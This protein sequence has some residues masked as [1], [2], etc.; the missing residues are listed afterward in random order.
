MN[1]VILIGRITK[2]PE[3]KFTQQ[4]NTSY[5]SFTLAV[6]RPTSDPNEKKADFINCVAWRETATFIG[7][8]IKKGYLLA[9]EGA[10]QTR[11]YIDNS[12]KTVY[13]TEVLVNRCDNLQPRE[14]QPQQPNN[15]QPNQYGV[16][17][18]AM[19][20][21]YYNQPSVYQQPQQSVYQQHQQQQPQLTFNDDDLPF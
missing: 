20:N 18:N 10:I 16:N 11:N 9:V 14:Q 6:N 15:Y 12:N 2:D 17:P 3:L 8:Y 4:N 1:K 7:S 19:P 21:Q 5:V 13:V